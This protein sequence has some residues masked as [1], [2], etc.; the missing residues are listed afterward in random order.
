[1][2]VSSSVSSS[3][4]VVTVP[5][6]SVAPE[7]IRMLDSVPWSPCSDVPGS[8]ATGIVTLRAS[9]SVSVAV[10]V[11]RSPSGTGSGAA[12]SDTS[13]S[14][15]APASTITTSTESGW[16]R[17]SPAGSLPP[18]TTANVSPSA[19]RLVAIRPAPRVAPEAIRMLDSVPWSPRSD[20]PRTTSTGIVTLRASAS[21]STAVTVTRSPSST[22]RGSTSSQTSGLSASAIVT[23]TEDRVPARTPAG[24]LPSRTVSGIVA[25]SSS[26]FDRRTVTVT[27]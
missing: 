3:T 16:P 15:G 10:T 11:T 6:P 14:A 8:T 5:V 7:A 17:P 21:A 26:A 22:A 25:A 9:A 20:V 1:M 23:T 19:S 2:N 4:L 13:E 27:S 12:E 24:G 18:S